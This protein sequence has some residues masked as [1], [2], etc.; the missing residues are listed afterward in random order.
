MGELPKGGTVGKL[1]EFFVT[2]CHLKRDFSS[3]TGESKRQKEI[4]AMEIFFRK[5]RNCTLK[6]EIF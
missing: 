5:A 3:P 6:S 2:F 1:Q 4:Y